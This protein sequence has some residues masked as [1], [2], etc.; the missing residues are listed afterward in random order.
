MAPPPRASFFC[1]FLIQA[2]EKL[3]CLISAGPRAST[4]RL[5]LN[6][7]PPR[8]TARSTRRLRPALGPLASPLPLPHRFFLAAGHSRIHECS[9]FPYPFL[10]PLP[11]FVFFLGIYCPVGV[12]LVSVLFL[13]HGRST[14]TLARLSILPLDSHPYPLLVVPFVPAATA[15]SSHHHLFICYLLSSRTSTRPRLSWR[16]GRG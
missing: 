1:S 7:R 12:F 11:F 8:P 4:P 5:L 9:F 14:W 10:V 2:T 16:G 6:R 13:R 3:D 15:H